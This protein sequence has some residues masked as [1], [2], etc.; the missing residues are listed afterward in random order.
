MSS[1][2][3]DVDEIIMS[4]DKLTSIGQLL[5]FTYPLFVEDIYEISEEL[6]Q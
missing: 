5:Y 2:E 6:K 4:S 3:E 1:D